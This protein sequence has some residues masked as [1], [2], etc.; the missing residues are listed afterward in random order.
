MYALRQAS[1]V[2]EYLKPSADA[3]KA[4][5]EGLVSHRVNASFATSA[6]D[7]LTFTVPAGKANAM[8][9]TTYHT[10]THG[11]TGS[12]GARALSVSLPASVSAHVA[13]VVPGV[14]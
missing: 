7:L 5:K 3:S 12:T 11:A 6:G 8:F 14:E 4:V 2:D 10:F 9:D 1:Q 13:S